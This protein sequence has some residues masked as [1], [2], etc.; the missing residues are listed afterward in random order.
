[1]FLNTKLIFYPSQSNKRNL[2][3]FNSDQ[4]IY[5]NLFA[6]LFLCFSYILFF[7]P[8]IRKILFYKYIFIKFYL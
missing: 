4:L 6:I 8:Q 2:Q 3:H 7:I 1:M 5:P